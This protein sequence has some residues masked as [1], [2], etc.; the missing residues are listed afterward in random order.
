MEPSILKLDDF[1]DQATKQLLQLLVNKKR[2]F[3][4]YKKR[5]LYMMWWTILS[6]FFL[7]LYMN[8]RIIEPNTYSFQVMLS[9]F[10]QNSFHLYAVLIIGSSFGAMNVWRKKKDKAEDEYHALRREVVDRSKDLWKQQEDWKKRHL[11]YNMMKKEFDI[12]LYHETK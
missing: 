4:K 12:N 5:H 9:A 11:V 10:V 7:L 8:E 6:A 2:K 3:A 1:T